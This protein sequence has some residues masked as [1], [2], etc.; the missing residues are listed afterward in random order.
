MIAIALLPL[1]LAIDARQLY[2]YADEP[3]EVLPRGDE[4]FGYIDLELPIFFYN[5]KYDRVYVSHVKM[6]KA[7]PSNEAT[8][9]GLG[10][11]Q[12]VINSDLGSRGAKSLVTLQPL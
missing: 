8:R 1:A 3:S 12:R 4:Q 6:C 11:A 9:N 5:E 10:A 7:P 2:S